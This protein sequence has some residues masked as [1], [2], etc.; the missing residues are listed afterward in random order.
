MFLHNLQWVQQCMIQQE[1]CRF[2]WTVDSLQCVQNYDR[3]HEPTNVFLV[4][5]NSSHVLCTFVVCWCICLCLY[6]YLFIFVYVCWRM[7]H[8]F[9][10]PQWAKVVSGDWKFDYV[11]CSASTHVFVVWEWLSIHC[12]TWKAPLNISQGKFLCICNLL[13]AMF[14]CFEVWRCIT[15]D[16]LWL[17]NCLLQYIVL[18]DVGN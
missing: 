5:A 14:I 4:S 13:T 16:V 8:M 7:S 11:C 2:C 3:K 6:L 12:F 9:Q 18:T 10:R 17:C 15:V 1:T